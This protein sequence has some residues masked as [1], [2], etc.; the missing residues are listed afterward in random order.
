VAQFLGILP[1]VVG[2]TILIL[3]WVTWWE[4][5]VMAGLFWLPIGGLLA[6]TGFVMSLSGLTRDRNAANRN[7]TKRLNL[8]ALIASLLSVP[9]AILCV[10]V[11]THLAT[12]P[13]FALTVHNN[14]ARR[15]DNI[16]I[17][18]NGGDETLGPIDPRTS[19]KIYVR[20]LHDGPL[21]MT[22]KVQGAERTKM[23]RIFRATERQHESSYDI[24]VEESELPK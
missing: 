20:T 19:R 13:A 11:G 4:W 3:H 15:I 18:F 12:T 5:L 16:T 6:F 10:N 21:K 2:L 22:T 8:V 24:F 23:D 1:S 14:A 17:H 9:I 7:V